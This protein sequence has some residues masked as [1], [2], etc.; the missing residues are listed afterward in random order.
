MA[1]VTIV[2]RMTS[3]SPHVY[4]H[5]VCGRS[6]RLNLCVYTLSVVNLAAFLIFRP[7]Y[8]LTTDW[9]MTDHD[10]GESRRADHAHYVQ[11]GGESLL[12][13]PLTTIIWPNRVEPI[14]HLAPHVTSRLDTTRHVR[15]VEPMHFGCVGLVEQ[16][17]STR[18]SRCAR[19]VERVVSCRDVTSQV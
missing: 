10:D 12:A 2:D 17:G 9:L 5:A 1:A 14:F 4:S 11:F 13:A 8:T 16:H 3:L 19:H 15:R 18:S 7:L 6:A